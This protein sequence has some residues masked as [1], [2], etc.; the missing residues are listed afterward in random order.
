[1]PAVSGQLVTVN[2]AGTIDLTNGGTSTTDALVVNGNYVGLNGKL[3]LQSV[4]NGDGSPS[5]KLV[6]V[7]GTGSGKATL[8]IT[9]VGGVGAATLTNGILVVQATGGATTAAGAFTLPKPLLAGAYTYYLFKGG[10]SAG[11]ADNWYLRSSLAAA[12]APTR[13]QH[14][15]PPHRRPCRAPRRPPAPL[16]YPLLR[17][18]ARQPHRST[19]WRCRS[20][21]KSPNLRVNSASIRSVRS[22]TARARNR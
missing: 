21:Q 11:T 15:H 19:G 7:Q 20:T 4:L 13:R 9:N 22:T 5:D 16:P 14:P 12:P 6:I 10:V 2:N 1:M 8:G 3:L 17:Q 18:R